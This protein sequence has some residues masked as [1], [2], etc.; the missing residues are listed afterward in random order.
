[1]HESLWSCGG[2]AILQLEAAGVTNSTGTRSTLL[3][4]YYRLIDMSAHW[5]ELYPGNGC[6]R[7]RTSLSLSQ[8]SLLYRPTHTDSEFLIDLIYIFHSMV[9][10]S[11]RIYYQLTHFEDKLSRLYLGSYKKKT[12]Y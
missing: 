2:R 6:F 10:S 5:T 8:K 9:S 1:M 11:R 3:L 7:E 12:Y 4:L